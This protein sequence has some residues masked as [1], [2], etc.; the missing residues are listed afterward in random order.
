MRPRLVGVML[1]AREIETAWE[2]ALVWR[3]CG[4]RYAAR[5]TGDVELVG[6]GKA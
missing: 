2:W 5:A 6:L 3:I 4:A 1:L